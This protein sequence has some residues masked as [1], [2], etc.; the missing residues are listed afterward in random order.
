MTASLAAPSRTSAAP[1]AQRQGQVEASA[2]LAPATLLVY[3]TLI[4]M[5]VRLDIAG[6]AIYPPRF[7]AF[8]LLPWLLRALSQGRLRRH[9]IDLMMFA[10]TAWMVISFCLY[11]DIST[12]FARGAPLAFDVIV[13]YL[14]ARLSIQNLTDLRRLLVY[15]APGFFVAGASMAAESLLR[16]QFVRPPLANLFGRLANYENGVAVGQANFFQ[17]TRFGLMRANG[18]FSHPI[19]GGI[20]MASLA[21]LYFMSGVRKWPLWLGLFAG[22]CSFFSLSSGAFLALII[23]MG[24]VGMD[25]V[26]KVVG[27]LNWRQIAGVVIAAGLMIH[28]VSNKGLVSIIIRYTLDPASGYY[29]QLIW[30][31]GIIS[32]Q[33]HPFIGVGLTDFERAAWMGTSVDN[34]WLL[35]AIRHGVIAVTALLGACAA[36]LFALSK[37]AALANPLD[38]NLYVGAFASL[39]AMTISCFSVAL[40]GGLLTWFYFVV[41]ATASIAATRGS[42]L[43]G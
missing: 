29:R 38:R 11:Y 7:I 21:P 13:P 19:L 23:G 30:D 20:L 39:F 22:C 43:R 36:S 37:R 40:F 9:P 33:N 28:M 14:V 41:G 34:Q 16:V 24:V 18:P 6:A 26:Q 12:G 5:E 42:Q 15:C 8:L 2:S 32:V 35:L 25:K 1:S 10:G 31:F 3:A 4:P 17:F 27:F